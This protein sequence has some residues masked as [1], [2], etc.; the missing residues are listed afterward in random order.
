LALI[1][2]PISLSGPEQ[3]PVELQA[4]ESKIPANRVLIFRRKVKAAK[5]LPVALGVEL[6]QDLASTPSSLEIDETLE[7][8][9]LRRAG[10][11]QGLRTFA[12]HPRFAAEMVGRQIP[13]EAC[14]KAVEHR[15]FPQIPF[16]NFLQGD[17]EGFLVEIVLGEA[18]RSRIAQDDADTSAVPLDQLLFGA[19]V[20][21]LDAPCQ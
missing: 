16:T 21:S 18:I 8:I 14:D 9:G 6:L 3:H 1:K 4:G 10:R 2:L 12:R 5:D 19:R 17:S 20:S 7:R 15:W 13:G 11:I